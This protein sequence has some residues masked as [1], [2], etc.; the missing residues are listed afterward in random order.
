MALECTKERSVASSIGVA[1]LALLFAL[2]LN[3]AQWHVLTEPHWVAP[4]GTA[5][6]LS[7]VDDVSDH[8]HEPHAAEDHRTN[9]VPRAPAPPFLL[10]AVGTTSV[11]QTLGPESLVRAVAPADDPPPL[12]F[13]P[14]LRDPRAPPPR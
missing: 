10:I 11:P 14:T 12:L 1:L 6:A 9:A 4:A 2:S 5:L 7:H 3:F 8:D 13:S